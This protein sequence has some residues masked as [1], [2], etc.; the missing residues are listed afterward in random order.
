MIDASDPTPA[1]SKHHMRALRP[2]PAILRLVPI[3]VPVLVSLLLAG[4]TT[5]LGKVPAVTQ[6]SNRYEITPPSA[7]SPLWE[8]LPTTNDP[9]ADDG[10]SDLAYRHRE[11]R[12]VISI[13]SSCRPK[14]ASQPQPLESY[15]A[16]LSTGLGAQVSRT[17]PFTERQ[18]AGERALEQ[19]LEL[20]PNAKNLP[21]RGRAVVLRSGPC[22]Y[23]L[24]LLA[25]PR[26]WP[27]H[28]AD[29]EAFVSSLRLRLH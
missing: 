7:R 27:T 13:N 22:L 5:L 21:L 9:E 2:H 29:F 11:T 4:C 16:Q 12:A 18:L 3:L 19:E 23:D 10:A 1:D 6:R 26:A 15:L 8:Q 17:Q 20:S 25:S 28:Q 14:F 24:I